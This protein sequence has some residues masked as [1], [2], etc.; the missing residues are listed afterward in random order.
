MRPVLTKVPSPSGRPSE[1]VGLAYSTIHS[2]V[3]M[4]SQI[5]STALYIK[6]SA[7]VVQ[8]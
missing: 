6:Q 5:S 2:P 4:S 8:K 1:Y 3:V 7:R